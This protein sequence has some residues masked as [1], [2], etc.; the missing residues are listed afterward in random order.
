[1][2]IPGLI[3]GQKYNSSLGQVPQGYGLGT[4]RQ[5]GVQTYDPRYGGPLSQVGRTE[6]SAGGQR[7]SGAYGNTAT[8][9][10]WQTPSANSIFG[11]GANAG[12]TGQAGF[13]NITT[14]I[15][16]RPIYSEDM[17]RGATNLAVAE[18]HKAG[19]LPDLLKRYDQ[20]GVS[21]GAGQTARA[22]GDAAGYNQ[23]ARRA[24]VE[25]PMEDAFTNAQ[26]ILGG[27]AAQAGEAQGLAG[28]LLKLM[29]NQQDL[30]YGLAGAQNDLFG[31]GMN[32][33]ASLFK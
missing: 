11:S 24:A 12:G 29:G 17:T 18:Q 4:P 21:R 15:T 1:V 31:T 33:A 6:S 23:A 13:G 20:H 27:Q 9:L 8:T 22:M 30:R 16:P 19:F 32:L 25:L 7:P 2:A 26:A 5:N 28:V 10:P 3:P 14:S